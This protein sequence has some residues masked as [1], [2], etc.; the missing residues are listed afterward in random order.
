MIRDARTTKAAGELTRKEMKGPDQFQ[1]AFTAAVEWA[2]ARHKLVL[3]GIGGL[4]AVALLAVGINSWMR[5][6]RDQA[7]G[8][9]YSALAAAAGEISA[10]PLPGVDRP[11]FRTEE[12]RARAVLD[13]AER[14][15]TEASGSRA[16]ATA[17]L[18]AGDAQLRLRDWD[19]AKASFEA[20]LSASGADESLRFA[21]H[22]GVARALEGKGDLAGA[23]QAF[24][25][26]GQEPVYKDRAALE[27]ARVLAKAGKVDEARKLLEAFPTDH[28]DSPLKSEAAE[29]LARLG[30][31]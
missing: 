25:K 18:V 19:K 27:R 9:L 17:A 24:E 15:R 6:S 20:F 22:D 26:A 11:L 16:A 31:K 29:R 4:A 1:V 23:A 2:A 30:G 14:V 13:A 12:D 21:A 8:R 7:G 3:A 28:K 10:V 5:S